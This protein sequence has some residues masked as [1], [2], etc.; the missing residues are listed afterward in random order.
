[1][2]T[3]C[4]RAI[5]AIVAV[6]SGWAQNTVRVSGKVTEA[7]SGLP[8]ENAIVKLTRGDADRVGDTRYTDVNGA[9]S[10]DEVMPGAASVS[11]RAEGFVPFQDTNPDEVAIQIAA[12]SAEHDFKL[13][14]SA[15]L[16][17]QVH[18][19]ADRTL[20][21]EATL[22]QENFADG[23]RHF[24]P[25]R[26][27]ENAPWQ[28]VSAVSQEGL[29]RFEGLPPGTYLL[30]VKSAISDAGALLTRNAAVAE[31]KD[32]LVPTYYPG[33]TE[34]ASAIPITLA[35]GESRVADFTMARR[36]LFRVSGE[37][38]SRG[39]ETNDIHLLIRGRNGETAFA[40]VDPD[41]GRFVTGGL[42]AGTYTATTVVSPFTVPIEGVPFAITDH[43]V[44]GLRI[45]PRFLYQLG[46]N[47]IFR[48]RGSGT[49]LPAGLAVQFAYPSPG[50]LS[51]IIAAAADGQ[52]TL[53][54]EAGDYSV[55]PIVPSGYAVTEIRYGGANYLHSLIPMRGGTLDS[56]LTI[57]LSD[58]PGSVTGTLVDG[59]Q[60][61]VAAK[62]VLAP[63]PLP[64]NFDFR[65]LRV[66]KNDEKGAFVFSGVAAGQYKAIV[67]TG[68]DR[69]RDHDLALFGDRLRAADAFEVIAGQ[70][71]SISIRP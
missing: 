6:A 71:L 31:V 70:S 41:S 24:G 12:D 4:K 33:T 19:K 3:F 58:Q 49:Q 36:A 61:P 40:S 60:K 56:S 30:R 51:D 13:V 39:I 8:V 44:E 67:L 66:V 25:A 32:G 57:V 16:L 14:R 10:F 22:L 43:N 29:F 15:S 38:D 59:N 17:V 50:D 18:E 27:A 54:G 23:V 68:D 20:F 48:M 1:M 42:P 9:Y 5:F 2:R 62:I 65:A 55:R 11:I 64:A 46:T 28:G 63:D 34:V 35:A 37:I 53:T 21:F 47:G 52:F 45:V 69:K 7:V 26:E